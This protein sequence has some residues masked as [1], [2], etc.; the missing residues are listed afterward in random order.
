MLDHVFNLSSSRCS[1]I[2]TGVIFALTFL[3]LLFLPMFWFLRTLLLMTT[4]CYCIFITN[5]L[6]RFNRVIRKTDGSWCLQDKQGNMVVTLRGDS[7]VTKWISILRFKTE[8]R[9][10]P[11]SCIIFYDSLSPHYYRK[12]LMLLQ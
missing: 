10:W 8:R 9:F 5:S 7:V 11:V 2:L 12:L 6:N 3:L 4:A 1:H